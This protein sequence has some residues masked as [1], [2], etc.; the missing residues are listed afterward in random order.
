MLHII[1]MFYLRIQNYLK[2]KNNFSLIEILNFYVVLKNS[3]KEVFNFVD[4]LNKE[5]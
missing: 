1:F 4:L 5:I 2:F 3:L